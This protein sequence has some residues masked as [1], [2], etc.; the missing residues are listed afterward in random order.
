MCAA[1]DGRS[2]RNGGDGHAWTWHEKQRN[3]A[4]PLTRAT[5]QTAE[6]RGGIYN[7]EKQSDALGP[8]KAMSNT[9]ERLYTT[10]TQRWRDY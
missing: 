1:G 7:V 8:L 4:S 9:V 5:T 3:I 10:L 6:P 2:C